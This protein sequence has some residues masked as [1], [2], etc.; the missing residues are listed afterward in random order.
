[1]EMKV[2][3]ASHLKL[4]RAETEIK[5]YCFCATAEY[6]QAYGKLEFSLAKKEKGEI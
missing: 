3:W 6:S 4:Q 5:C 1:M 2:T